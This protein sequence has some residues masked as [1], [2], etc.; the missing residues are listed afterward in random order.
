MVGGKETAFRKGESMSSGGIIVREAATSDVPAIA[1]LCEELGYPSSALDVETRLIEIMKSAD[2]AVFVAV[3]R[4]VV[5]WIHVF[6]ALRM[7]SDP[8]A[9]IGG[10]VISNNYRGRGAGR[11]LVLQCEEWT[12]SKQMSSLRVRSRLSRNDAHAF[13]LRLGF[14]EKK[15]QAVFDK[16]L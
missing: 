4:A 8:F 2:H 9:E 14:S 6:L 10:L 5:G 16:T 3:D 15:T 1:A 7:E 13:Y 12:R 11:K